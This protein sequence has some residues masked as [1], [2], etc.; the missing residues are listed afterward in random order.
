MPLESSETAGRE[1]TLPIRDK[2]LS[3]LSPPKRFSAPK[4]DK[5]INKSCMILDMH[6]D[7]Y[8]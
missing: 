1:F 8:R 5:A 2:M 7:E 4:A 6:I 3:P